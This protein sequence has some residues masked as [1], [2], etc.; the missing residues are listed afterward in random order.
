MSATPKRDALLAALAEMTAVAAEG[1]HRV[2]EAEAADDGTELMAATPGLESRAAASLSRVV[3]ASRDALAA[4][5]AGEEPVEAWIGWRCTA[6]SDQLAAM[7]AEIAAFCAGTRYGRC[8]T[9]MWR[10]GIWPIKRA[11]V[12]RGVPFIFAC[13]RHVRHTA[14]AQL[15]E[16]RIHGAVLRLARAVPPGQ[17][18]FA[19]RVGVV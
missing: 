6:A 1:L 19:C 16:V 10:D 8:D 2:R 12:G 5:E 13:R 17:I 4:A 14:A 3:G 7:A 11:W 15:F 9:T 18:P